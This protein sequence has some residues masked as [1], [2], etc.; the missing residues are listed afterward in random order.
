VVPKNC[1]N[2]DGS[3]KHR[4]EIDFKKLNEITIYI[5]IILAKYF[6]T[7]DLKSGF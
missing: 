1:Q 6:S 7:I 5:Y 2:E 3:P 4:L